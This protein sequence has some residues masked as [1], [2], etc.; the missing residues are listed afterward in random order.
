MGHAH[1]AGGVGVELDNTPL[2]VIEVVVL[3]PSEL[4]ACDSHIHAETSSPGL[5]LRHDASLYATGTVVIPERGRPKDEHLMLTTHE[6]RRG[7]LKYLARDLP[8]VRHLDCLHPDPIKV[9]VKLNDHSRKAVLRLLPCRSPRGR[10]MALMIM[11]FPPPCKTEPSSRQPMW[12]TARL[13]A[14]TVRNSPR[15]W[16]Q[17]RAGAVNPPPTRRDV[18]VVL[19]L[20]MEDD[21]QARHDPMQ[22]DLK[23]RELDSKDANS[24]PS[25]V[26]RRFQ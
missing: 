17:W 1:V 11:V 4:A 9:G 2:L 26:I 19:G 20:D 16:L 18:V 25:V 21:L 22:S 13:E 24:S 14:L 10:L 3:D 7:L 6:G 5:L 12:M 15:P 8:K 23:N